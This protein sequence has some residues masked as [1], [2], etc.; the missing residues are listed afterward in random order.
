MFAQHSATISVRLLF[1]AEGG[2]MKPDNETVAMAPW[3]SS[4][5]LPVDAEEL[6][7]RSLLREPDIG[8]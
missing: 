1:A 6:P 7:G 4:N 3:A 5:K 2:A 8:L